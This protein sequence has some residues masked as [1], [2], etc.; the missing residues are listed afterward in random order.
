MPIIYYYVLWIA[1][2]IA[3]V[4][5]IWKKVCCLTNKTH[6]L[7]SSTSHLCILLEYRVRMCILHAFFND[8]CFTNCLIFSNPK[9][10]A[11]KE[12][13]IQFLA[14]KTHLSCA[15]S[16]ILLWKFIFKV[17]IVFS[18]IPIFLEETGNIQF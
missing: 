15:K 13:L 8:W 14:C 16:F 7:V 17:C 6:V 10:F 1:L 11:A 12:W 5:I 4:A 2:R 9:L 18:F 3:E